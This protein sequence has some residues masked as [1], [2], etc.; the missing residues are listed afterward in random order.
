MKK[1]IRRAGISTALFASF[2][3]MGI[4]PAYAEDSAPIISL[5][6]EAS[7]VRAKYIDGKL[8]FSLRDFWT[9]VVQRD[10]A[11]II[12]YGDAQTVSD[13]W[14]FVCLQDQ[15]IY[16]PSAKKHPLTD[17]AVLTDGTVYVSAAF[18]E[19]TDSYSFIPYHATEHFIEF[20]NMIW[21]QGEIK[22]YAAPIPIDVK[23]NLPDF[24]GF[25]ETYRHRASSDF[26]TEDYTV[27]TAEAPDGS[28]VYTYV[29]KTDSAKSLVATARDE[30]VF[31][32]EDHGAINLYQP[33]D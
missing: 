32:V 7:H 11:K 30:Y 20:H 17:S 33:R 27:T 10:P 28:T 31:H 22:Q 6:G 5:N 14:N 18:L 26:L 29:S 25:L 9:N 19:D 8:Y 1:L 24:E 23:T 3:S 2:L 4:A 16:S 15:T 13:G 21:E 12:W